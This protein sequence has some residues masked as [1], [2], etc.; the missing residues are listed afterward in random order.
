M[1]GKLIKSKKRVKEHAEVFT[2]INIVNQ[3]IDMIEK[4]SDGSDPYSIGKTWLEPACGNGVFVG[5]IIRR[6]LLRC[7]SVLEALEALKDV[8]AIDIQE[9]NVQQAR[10]QAIGQFVAWVAVSGR[11]IDHADA[12]KAV[13]IV[14]QN[15]VVGD[16]LKPETIVLF[17]WNENKWKR[18]NED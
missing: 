14:A 18:L 8:Y 3:M 1:S 6:K 7:E 11:V 17:D 5:E 10:C 4:E 13:D 12:R 16:F 2:P 9:D 15:I